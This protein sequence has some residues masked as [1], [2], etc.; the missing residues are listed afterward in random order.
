[1]PNVI[2]LFFTNHPKNPDKPIIDFNVGLILNPTVLLGTVIGYYFNKMVPFLVV[3]IMFT[4]FLIIIIPYLFIR[5]KN[6]Y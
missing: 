6:A 2:L 4:I 1:M 3:N 5:G